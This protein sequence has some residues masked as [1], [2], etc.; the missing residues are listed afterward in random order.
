MLR[1]HFLSALVLGLATPQ[2]FAEPKRNKPLL[3]S[4]GTFQ[5]MPNFKLTDL[6]GNEHTPD[7]YRGKVLLINFWA[8]W[9]PPCLAE[10][11]S[12]A[13]LYEMQ[14]SRPFGMLAIAMSQSSEQVN[15]YAQKHPHPY[16]LLPDPDGTVSQAFNVKGLPTSYLTNRSGQLV[17]RAQG[18]RKWDSER[19]QRAISLLYS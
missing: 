1:R 4:L 14:K 15:D 7:I 17:F 18:G 13:R 12:M 19:M 10:M 2:L 16:P 9:C 3:E 5:P 11:D 8:T 6:Q